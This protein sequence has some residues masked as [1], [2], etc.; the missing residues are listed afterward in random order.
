MRRLV[1]AATVALLALQSADAADMAVD[2]ELILAIDVS[3]SVDRVEGQ[4]QREGYVRA[5][6][7]PRIAQAIGNGRYGRIAVTY[8]EWS[9]AGL[10]YRITPWW[11]IASAADAQAYSRELANSP[12]TGATGTSITSMIRT[13]LQMFQN[14]GY[15]APRRVIDIGGDGPNSNGGPVTAARDEAV[16]AG[17]T[18]NG[19]AIND[20]EVTWFSLTDLD[21]YY[22]E[23][24]IGGP[25][26]FVVAVDG[27]QA[28]AEAILRKLILEI[29]DAVP[30]GTGARVIPVQVQ[31]PLVGRPSRAPKYGPACDIGERMLR[32][33]QMGLPPGTPM[34]PFLR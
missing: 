31:G 33:D 8:V 5:F 12:I 7:D 3:S 21:Q 4:L 25:A 20:R 11:L 24:V 17:V 10:E 32:M 9:R 28:Y 30:V 2:L 16:A 18:I 13:G 23:C 34:G 14:N 26:A 6:A 27:F 29:A 15:D 19:I 1:A 22:E